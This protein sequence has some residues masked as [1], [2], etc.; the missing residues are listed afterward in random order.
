MAGVLHCIRNPPAID[1]DTGAAK[2]PTVKKDFLC[3]SLRDADNGKDGVWPLYDPKV[4]TDQI[5]KYCKITLTQGQFTK[6]DPE[7]FLWLSQDKWRCQTRPHSCY[8]IR[9]GRTGK[10]RKHIWMHREIMKTPKHLVCD[11]INR[12]GLDNRKKNLRNCTAMENLLNRGPYKNSLS[13]YKGVSWK[14]KKKKWEVAITKADCCKYLGSF[15]SEIEAA[16]AHDAAA[17]ILHGEF[18]YLNFPEK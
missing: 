14:N 12:D 1:L 6:V 18:A 7:D 3:G 2:W 4:H 16:K 11:H 13:K 10:K 5:G 17:K 9:N 15:E 8:A